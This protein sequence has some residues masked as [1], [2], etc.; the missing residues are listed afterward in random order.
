MITTFKSMIMLLKVVIM[1]FG[2]YN[3]TFSGMQ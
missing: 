1:L 2:K 3:H